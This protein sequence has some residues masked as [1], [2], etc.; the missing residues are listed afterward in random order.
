MEEQIKNEGKKEEVKKEDVK[1]EELLE[2]LSKLATKPEKGDLEKRLHDSRRALS[3]EHS[4]IDN[5][6]GHLKLLQESG[7]LDDDI[8]VQLKARLESY[9]PSPQDVLSNPVLPSFKKAKLIFKKNTENIRNFSGIENPHIIL[10][11]LEHFYKNVAND[12]G[13]AAIDAKIF[14]SAST[15]EE[16]VKNIL[17][18]KDELDD[19]YSHNKS[20]SLQTNHPLDEEL[21]KFGGFDGFVNAV[22]EQFESKEQELRNLR[23]R[24]SKYEAVT[25][26]LNI[27]KEKGYTETKKGNSVIPW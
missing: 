9:E 3:Q 25:E 21:K 4:K 6:K 12:E 22:S 20:V 27:R 17:N 18:L 14:D 19:F 5:L 16:V 10:N 7:E 11:N 13:R 8:Y 2:S 15:P 23:E 24:L 26:T 1:K